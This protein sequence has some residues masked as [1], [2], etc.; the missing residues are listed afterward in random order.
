MQCMDGNCFGVR[1]GPILA[2]LLFNIFLAELFLIVNS[3]N[4][5]NYA[6]T[7]ATANDMDSLIVLLEEAS[8]PLFTCFNKNLLKRSVHKC[9][10][11]VSSK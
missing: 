9:Y 7:Y 11:L 8:K 3:M 2:L 1:Q 6:D 4:I 10:L 5:A